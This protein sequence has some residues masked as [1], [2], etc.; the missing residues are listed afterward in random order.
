MNAEFNLYN[1][2]DGEIKL[3]DP[4]NKENL[5]RMREVSYTC[6][7]KL[8]LCIM[9]C[10]IGY[11]NINFGA[12]GPKLFQKL[13]MDKYTAD[14]I[15]LEIV[16]YDDTIQKYNVNILNKTNGT[17]NFSDQISYR[18]IPTI[19]DLSETL[20]TGIYNPNKHEGV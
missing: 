20:L 10:Y 7:K 8:L 19:I 2:S 13:Y 18:D 1:Q 6:I 9:P 11:N 15:Y 4:N 3:D 16:N 5:E 14:S 17:L 12:Y